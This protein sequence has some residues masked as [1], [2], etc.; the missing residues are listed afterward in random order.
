[1]TEYHKIQI[2]RLIIITHTIEVNYIPSLH[3]TYIKIA[4]AR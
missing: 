3:A 1:M 4:A 2:Y